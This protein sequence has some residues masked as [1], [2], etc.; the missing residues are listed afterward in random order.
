MLNYGVKFYEI[1]IET[2]DKTS[3]RDFSPPTVRSLMA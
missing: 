1:F 3:A 2:A